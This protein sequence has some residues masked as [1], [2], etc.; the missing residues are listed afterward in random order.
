METNLNPLEKA[1]M[2][3]VPLHVPTRFRKVP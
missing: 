3:S 1:T 2:V